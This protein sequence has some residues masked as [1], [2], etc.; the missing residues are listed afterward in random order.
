MIRHIVMVQFRSDVTQEQKNQVFLQLGDLKKV[1]PGILDFQCGSNSSPEHALTRGYNDLF[2][3]DFDSTQSRDDY[4]I[5]PA[6]LAA[7]KRLVEQVEGGAQGI[8]V[9]DVEFN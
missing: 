4:L 8:V 7:G 5:D 1:L 3:F 2:W 6:H 9:A